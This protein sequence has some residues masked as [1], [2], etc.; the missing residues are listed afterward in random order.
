VSSSGFF[1]AENVV[2]EI[3]KQLRDT[4]SH[5]VVG[6]LKNQ[7]NPHIELALEAKKED[8]ETV[9]IP[10]RHRLDPATIAVLRSFLRKEQIDILHTHNYKSDFYGF[11]ASLGLDIHLMTTCHT[12]FGDELK[13]RLFFSIDKLLL[14]QFDMVFV[15][16]EPIRKE[17][18]A[19]GVRSDKVSVVWNG[20]DIGRFSGEFEEM[21][22]L[23]NAR[24]DLGIPQKCDVIGTVGRMTE[25]KGH[26]YFIE[27]ARRIAKKHRNTRFLIVGDGPLKQSLMKQSQDLPVVFAG[28]RND[29]P[30]MYALMDIFVLPSLD[31]GLPMVLLEAMASRIPVI[32]TA[33]G[34]I[35]LVFEDGKSGILISSKDV[36]ALAGA[37]EDLLEHRSKAD[38]L[39]Q[40]AFHTVNEKFSSRTM[41]KNYINMYQNVVDEPR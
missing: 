17:V 34:E 41:A 20:I 10:C 39:S 8:I 9:I 11:L 14:N 38:R 24:D 13:M 25:Q 2:L 33:V 31:E 5:V 19:S 7:Y 37:I 12:W 1:G 4:G 40:S 28:V 22:T 16:S 32:A 26:V 27:A 21:K 23:E 29:M 36:S 30:T 3:A 15:V 35:P 6:V 18:L